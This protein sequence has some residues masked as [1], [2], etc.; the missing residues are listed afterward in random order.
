M[1]GRETLLK[2]RTNQDTDTD[3]DDHG[4]STR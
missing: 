2:D 4:G 1:E 3:G